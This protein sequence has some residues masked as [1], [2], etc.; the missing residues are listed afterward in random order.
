MTRS[1]KYDDIG[2]WSEIKLD[3]VRQYAAAC[4]R[5]V[6]VHRE[7]RFNMQSGKFVAD[8][9]P[10]LLGI[11]RCANGGQFSRRRQAAPAATD[12]WDQHRV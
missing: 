7:T 11:H 2:Y 3:I 1:P 12:P 5:I 6:T 9:S 10:L 4:S 8:N